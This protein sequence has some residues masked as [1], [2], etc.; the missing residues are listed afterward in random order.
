MFKK[1]IAVFQLSKEDDVR[2]VLKLTKEKYGRLDVT[3]NCPYFAKSSRMMIMK[4][5]PE[6]NPNLSGEIM[7]LLFKVN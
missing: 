7:E 1:K 5:V 4:D 3:I 6:E 2:N